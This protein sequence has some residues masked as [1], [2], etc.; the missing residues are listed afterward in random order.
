MRAE[1]LLVAITFLPLDL[2]LF[3]GRLKFLLLFFL[4]LPSFLR[5]WS[6]KLVK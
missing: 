2:T 6:E 4:K 1:A 3:L 5:H